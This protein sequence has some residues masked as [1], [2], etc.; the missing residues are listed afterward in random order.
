MWIGGE[1]NF[2]KKIRNTIKKER[3]EAI[4]NGWKGRNVGMT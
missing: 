4:Y 2:K 3:N 1:Y